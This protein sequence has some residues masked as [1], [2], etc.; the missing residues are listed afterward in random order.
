MGSGTWNSKMPTPLPNRRNIV[1]SSTLVDDRCEVYRNI[2]H[3]NMNTKQDETIFVIGGAVTLWK[4]RHYIN[5]VYLTTFK[6]VTKSAVILRTDS[7]LEGYTRISS[8]EFPDHTFDIYER[9]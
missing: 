4:L 9:T 8:E 5:R 2:N 1:L 6:L 7:Y 3:L